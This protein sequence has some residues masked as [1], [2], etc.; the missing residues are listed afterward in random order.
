MDHRGNNNNYSTNKMCQQPVSQLWFE[1]GAFWWH[2][3]AAVGNIEQLLDAHR[4]QTECHRHFAAVYSFLQLTQ[5]ANSSDEVDP[6]V[7][8]LIFYPEKFIENIV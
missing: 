8:P 2:H 7:G 3:V 1:P 4:V 5:T 6:F